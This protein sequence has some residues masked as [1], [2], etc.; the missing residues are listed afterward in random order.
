MKYARYLFHQFKKDLPYF[1]LLFGVEVL[2][3]AIM[4]MLSRT[5]NGDIY[6]QN[7]FIYGVVWAFVL[8][9]LFPLIHKAKLF[10]KRSCDVYLSLPLSKKGIYI[11]D[12][13]L[14]LGELLLLF[15]LF[16]SCG[17]LL[18]PLA[19]EGKWIGA[20]WAGYFFLY[21]LL[22]LL[23][24]YGFGLGLTSCANNILDALIFL[25]LGIV[26][27][28][29][30]T[31]NIVSIYSYY[32]PSRDSSS[33]SL[34][35]KYDF[36][37]FPPSALTKGLVDRT[38]DHLY[39][40]KA[41]VLPLYVNFIHLGFALVASLLGYYASKKWK[42]EESQTPSLRWYGYPLLSALALTFYLGIDAPGLV[43]N[44]ETTTLFV[45]FGIGTLLY[46]IVYFI[47]QR[48]IRL[49][50]PLLISYA[51]SI[52]FGYIFSAILMTIFRH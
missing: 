36:I 29:G 40:Y 16:Y 11:V 20:I 52:A 34:I 42:A 18:A 43:N 44:G 15:A 22:A 51:A 39:L 21:G 7:F 2:S 50:W 35:T 8:A 47:G 49:S 4:I 38:Y 30:L 48:K 12:A 41:E 23:T 10:S 1:F 26:A 17:L 28:F 31:C 32:Y 45:L 3:L 6:I 13:L 19:L 46:L 25:V 27:M 5:T 9:Y 24:G 37:A 33:F 14:G